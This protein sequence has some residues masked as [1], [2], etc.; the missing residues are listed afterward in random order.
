MD[1]SNPW[2]EMKTILVVTFVFVFCLTAFC[3]SDKPDTN[4]VIVTTVHN[5]DSI[6]NQLKQNLKLKGKDSTGFTFPL[7]VNANIGKGFGENDFGNNNFTFIDLSLD[8]N[9]YNKDVFLTFEAGY[10]YNKNDHDNR[11]GYPTIGVNYRC[12]R[13]NGHNFYLHFGIMPYYIFLY[14]ISSKYLYAI[15]DYIGLTLDARYVYT[16]MIPNKHYYFGVLGG[17]QIFTNR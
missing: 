1:N 14:T 10:I 5:Q 7:Q 2:I 3:Q 12:Y 13:E 9:L 16:Y 11:S 17:I 8:V 6:K 4:I 15:N